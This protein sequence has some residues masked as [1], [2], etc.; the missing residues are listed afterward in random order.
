MHAPHG[1]DFIFPKFF[2]ANKWAESDYFNSDNQIEQISIAVFP[3]G[4][5]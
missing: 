1:V 4:E 2:L 3:T 5:P